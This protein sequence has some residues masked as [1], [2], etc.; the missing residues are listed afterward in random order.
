LFEEPVS[1][2]LSEQDVESSNM[3]E[4]TV[5]GENEDTID[6]AFMAMGG[7]GKF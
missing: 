5:E 3:T 6:Q 7:F 4:S 1:Q 2:T